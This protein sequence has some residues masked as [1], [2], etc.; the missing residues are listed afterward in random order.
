MCNIIVLCNIGDQCTVFPWFFRLPLRPPAVSLLEHDNMRMHTCPRS[1]SSVQSAQ[2]D[3]DKCA[4][5]NLYL[6]K[7]PCYIDV[8]GK[9]F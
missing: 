5:R 3:V 1:D 2:T 6:K 4:L 9:F 8:E 7:V